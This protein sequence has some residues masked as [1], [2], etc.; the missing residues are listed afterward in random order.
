MDG[1]VA[2]VLQPEAL[3]VRLLAVDVPLVGVSHHPGHGDQVIPEEGHGSGHVQPDQVVH[4]GL[5]PAGL[6]LDHVGDRGGDLGL[7][8]ADSGGQPIIGGPI[9]G[10]GYAPAGEVVLA[11]GSLGPFLLRVGVKVEPIVNVDLAAAGH[12]PDHANHLKNTFTGR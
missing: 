1:L 11:V 12:G 2:S 6:S 3:L 7:E 5:V 4:G 9:F 10:A 8:L